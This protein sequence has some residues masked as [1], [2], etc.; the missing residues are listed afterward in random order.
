MK[1][2]RILISALLLACL[3]FG[4]SAASVDVNSADA[5]TLAKVMKGVGA[6]KA[7]AIVAYRKANGPFKSVMQLTNVKGI[8]KKTV[9]KN[10]AAIRV[11]NP[12]VKG[13]K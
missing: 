9:T 7:A 6:D 3:S 4:V 13:K 12:S 5:A 2:T 10:A 11:A 8:G 1:I